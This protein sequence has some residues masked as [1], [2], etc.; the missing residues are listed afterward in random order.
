M[1]VP[2]TNKKLNV[3]AWVKKLDTK[4]K[5][6]LPI[7]FITVTL[8]VVTVILLDDSSKDVSLFSISNSSLPLERDIREVEW[9]ENTSEPKS[10]LFTDPL[11]PVH[12]RA[13]K[14]NIY[15]MDYSDLRIKKYDRRGKFILNIGE[16]RGR[17]PGEFLT[18]TDMVFYEDRIFISDVNKREVLIFN[19]SGEFIDSFNFKRTAYRIAASESEISLLVMGDSL[20]IHKFKEDGSEIGSYGRVIEDQYKNTMALSGRIL[21]LKDKNEI[22]YAP[23]KASY[24]FYFDTEREKLNYAV[25][26]IDRVDFPD[27]RPEIVDGS[28]RAAAP[29]MD[30]ELTD[31]SVSND[32]LIVKSFVRNNDEHESRIDYLDFYSIDGKEYYNSVRVPV[33]THSMTKIG[34]TY[35]FIEIGNNQRVRAFSMIDE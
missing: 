31:I 16:G 4:L 22:I 34:N 19:T 3:G 10:S 11:N 32:T 12:I 29:R 33:V 26:T 9:I 15:V 14:N 27:S 8:T 23:L 13:H 17:G 35:Y 28:Y 30:A 21:H 6:T 5:I 18:F 24:L 1:D 20:L 25:Q 7:I 2:W